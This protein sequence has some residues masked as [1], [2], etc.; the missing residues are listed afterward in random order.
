MGNRYSLGID[1]STQGMKTAVLDIEE[2]RLLHE[3]SVSYVRDRR[4]NGYGINFVDCMVPPREPGDADQPPLMYLAALDAV[5]SDLRDAGCDMN[6]ICT[7]S[8][9]A[10]QH[11]H[12]YLCEKAMGSFATLRTKSSADS[13]LADTLKEV[14]SYGL[15]PIWKTSNT[16]KE[17]EHIRNVIGGKGEM[18]LLSGSNSPAKFT[19]AVIRR[20]ALKY[21]ELY[22]RTFRIQLISSFLSGVLVGDCSVPIDYG[23][24]SGMSLMDYRNKVW[25][26][27][28]VVAVSEGLPGGATKLRSVL[29]ELTSPDAVVGTLA[30]YFQCKYGLPGGCL[31]TAGSGDNPQT[32]VLVEGDL[33]SIGTSMVIMVSSTELFDMNGYGLAMYDGLGRP[34]KFGGRHNGAMVWDFIRM[35]YG[36]DGS[37]F[38]AE[39]KILREMEPARNIFIWQPYDEAFPPSAAF[40]AKRTGFSRGTVENDFSGIV[41]SSLSLVFYYSKS[42]SSDSGGT[43]YVTGGVAKNRQV[44]RRI[45]AIWNKDVVSIQSAGAAVGAAVS[46]AS[47]Y[48]KENS[49]PLDPHELSK[50]LVC[51]GIRIEPE[52]TLVDRYS[53][54]VPRVIEEY[55]KEVRI[56]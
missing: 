48:S 36:L 42:F 17:A 11:G 32:K 20:V 16:Q 3:V 43:L 10:Q 23:N 19:G 12:V 55:E 40:H 30:S 56:E 41:D 9:S 4:L 22:S 44:L 29:P 46:A 45:A 37:D 39:T 49:E 1:C 38:R 18:I 6:K 21:P 7:V 8:V 28:L 35:K 25:S 34:F 47:A 14:F 53:G 31:V 54:Y 13:N 27:R 52:E 5:L 26:D 24:G 33:L 51:T 2:R 15:C 50:A